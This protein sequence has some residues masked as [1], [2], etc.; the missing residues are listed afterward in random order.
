MIIKNRLH[1]GS[2]PD[3]QR[4][5]FD[6][7]LIAIG[8]TLDFASSRLPIL[9]IARAPSALA[10]HLGGSVDADK[11]NIAL[12]DRAL[13]IGTEKE[14]FAAN[15]L[16]DIHKP[17]LIDRQGVIRRIP[18]RNALGID[19][20]NNNLTIGIHLGDNR[21]SRPA[22]IPRTNTNYIF[23]HLILQS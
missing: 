23:I 18:R 14:I 2:R 4:R 13:D 8:E 16:D 1:R 7:N 21:H 6:N 15:L 11:N 3:R 20:D 22:D 5:L 12:L 19:I 17:R 9:K 10:E